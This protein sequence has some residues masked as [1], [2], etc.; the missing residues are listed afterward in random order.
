MLGTRAGVRLWNYISVLRSQNAPQEA[1]GWRRAWKRGL[2]VIVARWIVFIASAVQLWFDLLLKASINH[3]AKFH[4]TVRDV[5]L[6]GWTWEKGAKQTKRWTYLLYIYIYI[7][8]LVC[9]SDTFS[10]Y[11]HQFLRLCT[12]E[13][14]AF[15]FCFMWAVLLLFKDSSWVMDFP[16]GSDVSVCVCAMAHA[17]WGLSRWFVCPAE[18]VCMRGESVTG[19]PVAALSSVSPPTLHVCLLSPLQAEPPHITTSV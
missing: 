12:D 3:K 13:P 17:C 7:Y 9:V 19:S 5:E 8:S 4:S 18:W 6:T 14:S 10:S 1:A 16:A 2:R 11:T 15:L